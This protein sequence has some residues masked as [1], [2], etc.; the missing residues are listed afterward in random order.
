MRTET[1]TR[2]LYTFE[3]LSDKAKENARDWYRQGFDYEWWDGVYED[4]AQIGLK[5]TGF[6]FGRSREITGDFTE[7]AQTVVDNIKANHGY[8]TET[9]KTA[10]GFEGILTK[11][12]TF[13]E[14]DEETEYQEEVE[15]EDA[16]EDF[17]KALLEDYL[18]ML[19]HEWD[20]LNS[21]EQVDE[22]I[23]ANEYEFTKNG[24]IA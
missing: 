7:S 6:D 5:I 10:V 14:S 18:I 22:S 24:H 3:E 8:Q 20:Y 16:I 4:A 11:T 1:T 2:T 13:V 19:D 23:M 17:R 15:D 12:E 21:D 9:Y